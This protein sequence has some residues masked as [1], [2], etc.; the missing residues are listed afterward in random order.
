VSDPRRAELLKAKEDL[1]ALAVKSAISQEGLKLSLEEAQAAYDEGGAG[2]ASDG[3]T[4]ARRYGDS[5]CLITNA[6]SGIATGT[7]AIWRI[8]RIK[9][10]DWRQWWCCR[11]APEGRS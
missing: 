5:R 9:S 7:A 3:R 4:A 8:L 1:K 11:P 2:I 6:R 10:S